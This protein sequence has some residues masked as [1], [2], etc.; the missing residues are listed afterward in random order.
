[1]D[2]NTFID[3]IA[4]ICALYWICYIPE[5]VFSVDT[6]PFMVSIGMMLLIWRCTPYILFLDEY[7]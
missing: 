1:M 5:D 3:I 7:D 2:Y 6:H 4:W